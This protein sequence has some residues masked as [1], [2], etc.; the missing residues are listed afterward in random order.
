M[1]HSSQS[2]KAA[3]EG[4]FPPTKSTAASLEEKFRADES[5]SKASSSYD[6]ARLEKGHGWESFKETP[7][8]DKTQG[9]YVRNIRHQIFS[10][11]RR[12]FGVVFATNMA[13]LVA[14][15]VQGRADA[16]RL[17]LIAVANL[18]VSILM[19]QEYVLNSFFIVFTAVPTS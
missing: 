1:S 13:V 5:S 16:K 10:L 8:P 17:G 4:Q 11:Y 3:V 9:K 6:V 12:L 19:R 18:F 15:C 14:L 7:L 2:P